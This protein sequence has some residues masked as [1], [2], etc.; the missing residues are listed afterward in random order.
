MYL[1]QGFT[2][3]G[4]GKTAITYIEDIAKKTGLKNLVAVITGE[5]TSSIKLFEKAGY[6]KVGHL[7]NIGEKFGRSL[8]VISY[9][10]E[11]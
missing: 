9:Q 2:G 1:K 8:D 5:N 11:I 10:K 3:K 7:I 6:F 4:I